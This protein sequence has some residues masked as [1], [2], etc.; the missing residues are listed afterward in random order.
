M[1]SLKF[2]GNCEDTLTESTHN[3]AHEPAP[4]QF[5]GN[6]YTM[7]VFHPTDPTNPSFVHLLRA[8]IQ[9]APNFFG[10]APLVIDMNDL[11]E[12]KDQIDVRG[13]FDLLKQLGLMPVGVQGGDAHLQQEAISY[14]LPVLPNARK[15][16]LAEIGP[17]GL[18]SDKGQEAEQQGTV[19]EVVQKTTMII[20]E[21]VRSGQ[22]IYAPQGDLICM[23]PISAG[24]EVLA[25]GNIHL[26]AP[27][28]GRA[29][30]GVSGD[31]SARIFCHSLEAE[32]VSIAGLYRVSEDIDKDVYKKNVQIYLKDGYMQMDILS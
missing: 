25:D 13:L 28:R 21:P 15:K 19:R 11:L 4:F 23:A 9:Q 24:A 22:Q 30:A 18:V 3:M 10:N 20:T 32:L 5:R 7:M 31:M 2:E 1:L 12:V 14:G 17:K 26:Y 16:E 8:K 27:L 6:Q 29:L